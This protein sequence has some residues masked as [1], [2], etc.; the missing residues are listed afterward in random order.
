MR[1]LI[2][3][4][5]DEKLHLGEHNS[6]EVRAP[7]HAKKLVDEL[8]ASEAVE[9]LLSL[10][11]WDEITTSSGRVGVD[12]LHLQTKAVSQSL[13]VFTQSIDPI[14]LIHYAYFGIFNGWCQEVDR[15]SAGQRPNVEIIGRL[16][17]SRPTLAGQG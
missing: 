11:E 2:E 7:I 13:D 9:T 8:A 1:P 3:M 5:V 12:D 6:P 4:A 15:G 17:A 16:V 14:N 10:F